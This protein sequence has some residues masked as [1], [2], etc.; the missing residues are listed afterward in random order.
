[1][2]WPHSQAREGALADFSHR[3]LQYFLPSDAAHLQAGWEHFGMLVIMSLSYLK[4]VQFRC[5][6]CE[7]VGH[8]S[9]RD[10]NNRRVPN[11][12]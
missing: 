12:P 3:G 10:D 6:G 5:Q 11:A 9:A 8:L 7:L 4:V 1:M 2:A